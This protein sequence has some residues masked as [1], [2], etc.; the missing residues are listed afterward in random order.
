MYYVHCIFVITYYLVITICLIRQKLVNYIN[1][2]INVSFIFYMYIYIYSE[3]STYGHP[4]D[5][6]IKQ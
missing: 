3:I 6:L 5:L 1:Y 2:F 4:L